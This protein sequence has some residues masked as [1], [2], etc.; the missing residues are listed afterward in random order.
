MENCSENKED[1]T[2]AILAFDTLYT[3][4]HMKILKLLLPYLKSE[5]QKKLAI[6]IKWQELIFT[7][8]FFRQYSASLYSPDFTVRKTLEL[9]TLLP[10]LLPY[11]NENEKNLLSHFSEIQNIMNMMESFQEYLPLIQQFMSSMSG[12]NDSSNLF[13]GGA[14]NMMDMLKNMMSEEQLAMFSMFMDNNL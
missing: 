6:Y 2:D 11:C 10:L 3:T 1:I 12:G 14:E 5:H 9:N 8:N 13:G 7:L 4:N